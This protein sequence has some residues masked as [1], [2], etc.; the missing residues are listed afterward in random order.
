[1]IATRILDFLSYCKKLFV[2][3][4]ETGWKNRIVFCL[5]CWLFGMTIS[6]CLILV[7]FLSKVG[8][9]LVNL[10][11]AISLGMVVSVLAY[12][13]KA[14]RCTGL[15][16]LLC[17]GMKQGRNVLIAIGSSIVVFNN[18]KNILGN[19]RVLA[20]CIV[21]NVETKRTLLKVTPLDY[22]IR[23]FYL[24]YQNAK[25]F[26]F[27]P[28]QGFVSLDDD[29][30]CWLE[31]SDDNLKTV[32]N[33]TKQQI[34]DLS[35]NISVYLDLITNVGRIAFLVLGVSIILIGAIILLKKFLGKDNATYE[36]VYITKRFMAY[37][38]SCKKRNALGVLPLNKTEKNI[39]IAIPSLKTSRTQKLKMV[40]FFIPVL[41][42]VSIWTVISVLD[43]MLYWV[44]LTISKN[45]QSLRPIEVPLKLT[46]AH[47]EFDLLNLGRR[48]NSHHAQLNINLFEPQC[49]PKPNLSLPDTWIPLAI[50]IGVLL[51]LVFISAFLVQVKLLLIA[52]FYPDKDMERVTYLHQKIQQERALLSSSSESAKL[53]EIIS[54]VTNLSTP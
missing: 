48:E 15:L 43:F 36:N 18:V 50:I 27:N 6:G 26:F 25:R 21:C 28:L 1:M 12:V 11:I 4:R 24:I 29:F 46:F 14:V 44:I 23:S 30:K 52:A 41:T 53:K 3:G 9:G 37:D 32:L 16:F 17:C 7:F 47:T 20:E 5:L 10:L 40:W 22:Y 39:Y 2:S 13:Y 42:H 19:L 45:L 31:I 34:R 35:S 38:E 33:E 51:V 8:L 54:Q 49:T